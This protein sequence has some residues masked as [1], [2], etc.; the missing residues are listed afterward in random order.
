MI[1]PGIT[2]SKEKII[3]DLH[4]EVAELRRVLDQVPGDIYWKD[5]N[6]T[7]LGMNKYAICSMERMGWDIS[8]GFVG[9]RDED[10]FDA[11]TTKRFR[12]NDCRV[13][14]TRSLITEEETLTT[15][16][17]D[18]YIQVSQKA[19]FYSETGKIQGVIGNTVNVTQ[20]EGLQK[21]LTNLAE[22]RELNRAKSDFLADISHDLRTPITGMIGLTRI[23]KK[24]ANSIRRELDECSESQKGKCLQ[25]I[26]RMASDS[27]LLHD[28]TEQLLGFFNEVLHLVSLDSTTERDQFHSFNLQELIH[29]KSRLYIPAAHAK[30]LGF[31]VNMDDSLPAAAFGSCSL[32]GRIIVNLLSNA[33]KF[34]QA[35]SITINA[36]AT[37]KVENSFTLRLSVKDTGVGISESKQHEI[38]DS[39]SR[40][41]PPFLGKYKGHGLG[42]YFVKRYIDILKGTIKMHSEPGK[43]SEFVIELPLTQ[44]QASL[45]KNVHELSP[46]ELRSW[47]YHRVLLVEDDRLSARAARFMFESLGFVVDHVETGSAAVEN[48]QKNHYCFII[49]DIGLPDI[50]G[51]EVT[52][53]IHA[54]PGQG[55]IPVVALSSHAVISKTYDD[56]GHSDFF[57]ILK[58]PAKLED[59]KCLLHQYGENYPLQRRFPYNR[60]KMVV[61]A[62]P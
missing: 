18:T 41:T 53:Q 25:L 29:N 17:A 3:D 20:L 9:L 48:A 1:E 35:G 62:H 61:P 19:P 45:K 2:R 56:A 7:Y 55:V 36:S 46:V 33:I 54:I 21:K 31:H 47:A 4:R 15:P 39:F 11:K 27:D 10:I 37:K 60:C 50:D 43:G 22:A 32:L 23:L 40:L 59:I 12:H 58:K 8:D 16:K 28:S 38:F 51:F 34:T 57:S 49:M 44:T 5:T 13:L 14:E 26:D 52:R 24:N 30:G 42:L 6:G